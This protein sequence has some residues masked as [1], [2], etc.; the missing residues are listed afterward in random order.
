MQQCI[1]KI[2]SNCNNKTAIQKDRFQNMS[3]IRLFVLRHFYFS[4]LMHVEIVE[5]L[6]QMISTIFATWFLLW[7]LQNDKV[8][9]CYSTP[10]RKLFHESKT[11]TYSSSE[12]DFFL[13]KP[14]QQSHHYSP[15]WVSANLFSHPYIFAK[16]HE[17]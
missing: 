4:Y 5:K 6:M 7:Q 14:C 17:K 8:P 13:I 12:Y 11:N 15:R 3:I 16:T 2:N 1:L 10:N 9:Y